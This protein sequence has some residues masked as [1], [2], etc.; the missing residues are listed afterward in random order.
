MNTRRQQMKQES[1]FRTSRTMT[2]AERRQYSRPRRVVPWRSHKSVCCGST[3]LMVFS[4]CPVQYS[5]PSTKGPAKQAPARCTTLWNEHT[6]WYWMMKAVWL[7]LWDSH[8]HTDSWVSSRLIPAFCSPT[9]PT[10]SL[11]GVKHHLAEERR[12]SIRIS[13]Q[14]KQWSPLQ[15]S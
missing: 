12:N 11:M 3:Q 1:G 15:T 6:T 9:V 7:K 8:S 14:R 5:I 4:A 10:C 2:G 13:L